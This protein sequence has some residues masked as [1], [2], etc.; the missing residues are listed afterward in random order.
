[1]AND[2]AGRSAGV[3]NLTVLERELRR[4]FMLRMVYLIMGFLA[5]SVGL[6]IAIAGY[7][8]NVDFHLSMGTVFE[9]RL[10]NATPG[11]VIAVLGVAYSWIA[12]TGFRV[13]TSFRDDETTFKAYSAP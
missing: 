5:L 2:P 13:E 11:L 4:R 10:G 6:A 7:A 12:A 3:S 1:M 9:A 8:G